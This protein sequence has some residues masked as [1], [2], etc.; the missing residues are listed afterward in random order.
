MKAIAMALLLVSTFTSA[1]EIRSRAGDEVKLSLGHLVLNE[2]S[3]L[4]RMHHV[5]EVPGIPATLSEVAGIK[6]TYSS[7]NYSW[8]SVKDDITASDALSAVEVR[9]LLIDVFGERIATL[10]AIEVADMAAG[11]QLYP[12]WRWNVPFNSENDAKSM[13]TTVGWVAQVRK[14]NGTVAKA[15]EAQVLQAIKPY[16][17]GVKAADLVP[18]PVD[19][20]K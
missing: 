14:S 8:E 9:F 5:I 4:T 12:N 10:S 7:G 17:P 2:K 11:G 6:T 13:L 3:T 15:N 19:G 18:T 20:E 16:M 1:A